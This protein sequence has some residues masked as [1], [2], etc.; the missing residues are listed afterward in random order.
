M[1]LQEIS[2]VL[3][4]SLSL[5]SYTMET[6]QPGAIIFKRNEDEIIISYN[7]YSNHFVLPPSISCRR[8]FE[9]VENIL[10]KHFVR[11]GVNYARNTIHKNSS[12]I[13]DMDQRTIK[14]T[15]DLDLILPE[16]V[17]L[18]NFEITPFLNEF[19]SLSKVHDRL[20]SL[21]EDNT[22]DFI[23]SPIHPR[24]MTIKSILI[25]EDRGEY[26]DKTISIYEEH[27]KGKYQAAF[28]PILDFLPDLVEELKNQ[29]WLL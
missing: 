29:S 26:I 1:N 4:R 9:S 8:E 16:Y 19:D 17:S 7:K 23:C 15:E 25:T 28:K 21:N 14:S 20:T 18:M 2:N 5:E 11:H 10:E 3:K 6:S 27:S 24:I 12:R 22:A 13:E